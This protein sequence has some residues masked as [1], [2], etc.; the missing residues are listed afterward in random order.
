[1]MESSQNYDELF[2]ALQHLKHNKHEVILF[3]VTDKRHEQDFNFENRPYV[4]VDMESGEEVKVHPNQIKETYLQSIA[5]FKHNL[6]LKCGQY[7]IDFIDADINDG[8]YPVLNS[9]LVKRNRMG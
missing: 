5:A 3:N 6:I 1:M 2:S 7:H 8:F 9:Y 4:F